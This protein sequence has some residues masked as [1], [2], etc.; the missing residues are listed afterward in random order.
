MPLFDTGLLRSK[1]G[2]N[3]MLPRAAATAP[4][5]AGPGDAWKTIR[6]PVRLPSKHITSHYEDGR[7]QTVDVSKLNI[8][9]NEHLPVWTTAQNQPGAALFAYL[10]GALVPTRHCQGQTPSFWSN[11]PQLGYRCAWYQGQGD[12]R[13][14]TQGVPQAGQREIH[15]RAQRGAGLSDHPTCAQEDSGGDP[16]R[17]HSET[18]GIHRAWWNAKGSHR[19]TEQRPQHPAKRCQLQ[20]HHRLRCH[21]FQVL[22][23]MVSHRHHCNGVTVS[24]H[25]SR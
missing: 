24:Q 19:L 1:H 14:A 5:P 7:M 8:M 11:H 21:S 22:C 13:A 23:M 12:H 10:F 2:N 18:S 4:A 15:S 9:M 20:K 3:C 6:I 25:Q 16:L 17:Q